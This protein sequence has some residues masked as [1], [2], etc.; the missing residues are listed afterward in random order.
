MG[1]TL[2]HEPQLLLSVCT[3]VQE[4]LQYSWPLGQLVHFPF[5]QYRPLAP[6]QYVP[7]LPQLLESVSVLTQALPHQVVPVGHW[8]TPLV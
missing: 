1:H 3:S 5:Q 7:Q 6:E 8:Q 4:L 2:P